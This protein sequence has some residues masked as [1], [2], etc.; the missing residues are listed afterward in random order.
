MHSAKLCLTSQGLTDV[1]CCLWSLCLC[2][3]LQQVA[4]Q[5]EQLE[6]PMGKERTLRRGRVWV[7][8]QTVQGIVAPSRLDLTARCYFSVLAFSVLHQVAAEAAQV[9]VDERRER[10]KLLEEL[11]TKVNTLD[12][13]LEMR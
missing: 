7:F 4:A 2:V 9:Q 8:N 5:G 11:R 3:G 1:P 13:A 6:A 12:R 10:L